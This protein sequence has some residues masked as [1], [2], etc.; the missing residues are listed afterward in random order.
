MCPC[1]QTYQ[2]RMALPDTQLEF[3]SMVHCLQFQSDGAKVG[4]TLD[5]AEQFSEPPHS[6]PA[7]NC[8]IPIAV[9]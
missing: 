5:R 6:I 3:T 1:R 7:G 4:S 9:P 8:E 2:A